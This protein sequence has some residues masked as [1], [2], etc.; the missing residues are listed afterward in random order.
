MEECG[1][2][3]KELDR[4]GEEIGKDYYKARDEIRKDLQGRW[5]E[6]AVT[7]H[8]RV[9]ELLRDGGKEVLGMIE[10]QASYAAFKRAWEEWEGVRG[11]T[12][13]VEVRR[14]RAQRFLRTAATVALEGRLGE[15]TGEEREVYERLVRAEGEGWEGNDE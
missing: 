2:K 11:E 6:L 15:V 8:P 13:R 3:K 9:G 4:R 1:V 12:E 5:P 7:W 10:G 14:A